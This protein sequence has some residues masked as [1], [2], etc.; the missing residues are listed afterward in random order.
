MTSWWTISA[1]PDGDRA[2]AAGGWQLQQPKWPAE[3]WCHENAGILFGKGP[4]I[5]LRS[6]NDDK[7]KKAFQRQLRHVG[8]YATTASRPKLRP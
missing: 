2:E 5:R 3:I 1:A 8:I 6:A 4:H 7:S